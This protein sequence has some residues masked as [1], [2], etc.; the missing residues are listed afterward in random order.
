L[1]KKSLDDPYVQITLRKPAAGVGQGREEEGRNRLW[2]EGDGPGA[3]CGEMELGVLWASSSVP[4][5]RLP[6]RR[7]AYRQLRAAVRRCGC[8]LMPTDRCSEPSSRQQLPLLPWVGLGSEPGQ[9]RRLWVGS[10]PDLG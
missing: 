5:V 4:A 9:V 6:E 3:T 7:G 10:T 8:G 1:G 2:G